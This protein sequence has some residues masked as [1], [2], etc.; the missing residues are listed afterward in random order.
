MMSGCS[1]II[2][3]WMRILE[4]GNN[5]QLGQQLG[6]VETGRF[7]EQGIAM[8]GTLLSE[9]SNLKDLRMNVERMLSRKPLVIG[10]R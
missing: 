2:C 6:F 7:G 3:R 4:L 10:R 8:Q 5:A 1:P 9:M